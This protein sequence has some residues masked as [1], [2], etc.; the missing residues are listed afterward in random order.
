MNIWFWP[1][2]IGALSGVGLL[3]ALFSDDWGD[4]LSWLMLLVPVAL[5]VWFGWPR[6]PARSRSFLRRRS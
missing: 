3:S 5:S 2:V 6:P 4:W 1:L